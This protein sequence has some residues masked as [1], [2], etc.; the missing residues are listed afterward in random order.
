MAE[1]KKDSFTFSDKIKN[2]KPAVNPFAKKGA[3][4]IGNNGKPKQ[5]LFERSRRDA[6]F[7][8]AAAAALLM[9]PFL[10]KYSGNVND[11]VIVPPGSEDSIFDPERFGFSP[12]NEDPTGQIAQLAGRDPLSLIKGWGNPEEEQEAAEPEYESRDAFDRDYTPAPRPDTPNYRQTAPVATRAAFQRTP[13]KIKD[14]S[15]A[16]LNL[17]GGGGVGS[18]FGGAQLKA[19]ARQSSASAPRRGAQARSL[20]PLRSAA[21]PSR[22]YFGQGG[23][24]QARASRDALSKANAA[25]ALRDAMF[26][27]VK[28]ERVGGLADGFFASGGG[29]GKIDRNMNFKG[30]EPWWWD[31]MKQQEM[32]RW[33]WNYFLWRKGLVEPLIAALAQVLAK[34][35][36]NLTCCIVMGNSDCDADTF[37]GSNGTGSKAP[38]C[39][40]VN[41]ERFRAQFPAISALYPDDFKAACDAARKGDKGKQDCPSGWKAGHNYGTK[42]NGFQTR[43]K[44]L[45]GV[46][47]G[48]GATELRDRYNCEA[49]NTTQNFELQATGQ[50]AKWKNHYHVV[51]VDNYVPFP[52]GD[53]KSHYLCTSM[54][55]PGANSQ[56]RIALQNV[57]G[58]SED[59]N[60]GRHTSSGQKYTYKDKDG[61]TVDAHTTDIVR[62][63]INDGCVIYVAKGDNFRWPTFKSET[64]GLLNE[65]IPED[66]GISGEEAFAQLRLRFIE[67]YAM[68][69]TLARKWE[70]A[71]GKR[72][73]SKSGGTHRTNVYKKVSD[74]MI[75]QSI[76]PVSYADFESFYVLHRSSAKPSESQAPYS[77]QKKRKFAD[78]YQGVDN[79]TRTSLADDGKA[80]AIRSEQ[81]EF[82]SFR[83]TAREIEYVEKEGTGESQLSIAANL[84]FDPL[85]YPKREDLVVT[86]TIKGADGKTVI[87]NHTLTDA[88]KLTWQDG[89]SF[90]KL[91]NEKPVRDYFKNIP[92]GEKRSIT[93]Y[94]TATDPKTKKESKDQTSYGSEKP[95]IPIKT[96]SPCEEGQTL[97]EGEVDKDGCPLYKKCVDNKWSTEKAKDP[98]CPNNIKKCTPGDT[99]TIP[100]AVEGCDATITCDEHGEWGGSVTVD[101]ECLSN[102]IKNKIKGGAKQSCTEDVTVTSGECV[103]VIPC[104]NGQYNPEAANLTNP[105]CLN[106]FSSDIG[107]YS[108]AGHI[109]EVPT[110]LENH[111]KSA[112][113]GFTF[114]PAQGPMYYTQQPKHDQDATALSG[115]AVDN[116]SSDSAREFVNEVLSEVNDRLK[117]Q[118]AGYA[119]V[120]LKAGEAPRIPQFVD[121]MLLA[122]NTL[123][124]TSVPKAAVCTMARGVGLSSYD[125]VK[126]KQDLSNE[127]GSFAI[128]TGLS[129]AYVPRQDVE[130]IV[131]GVKQTRTNQRFDTAPYQAN[132]YMKRG[133]QGITKSGV[134]SPVPDDKGIEGAMVNGRFPLAALLEDVQFSNDLKNP[135]KG[136]WWDDMSKPEVSQKVYDEYDNKIG[137]ILFHDTGRCNL[138]GSQ[139][140]SI[141]DALNYIGKVLELGLDYKPLSK[142]DSKPGKT[143][144]HSTTGHGGKN[145]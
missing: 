45:G 95:M 100:S 64:I 138:Y 51:V 17:R 66:A 116:R 107:L 141:Q 19:A 9:L 128:Y 143:K 70:K 96:K 76:L 35:G 97:W 42:M 118:K 109:M 46:V 113:A 129:S 108:L 91:E 53:D 72:V 58:H 99:K 41:E 77:D 4:K 111:A 3:S 93:A 34:I 24:A 16:S 15:G 90:I 14:L 120:T 125:P 89:N 103:Y 114:A 5:T 74:G 23:A 28:N 26:A 31:M 134:Q 71:K 60:A 69:Q 1:N 27:P 105:E 81:C 115:R 62:D 33:K 2:S 137:S 145:G 124:R 104:E 142:K 126:V 43:W 65:M 44:C 122:K 39:C 49:I 7:M 135:L 38:E 37:V 10:Y 54:E 123:G 48:S 139:E 68:K 30:M 13:T 78:T 88:E 8:V 40:G 140:M 85:R 79:S 94:W 47:H 50:A 80:T 75:D 102:K 98:N 117:S 73:R 131:D 20:T 61:K 101:P 112:D 87:D 18:R 36:T 22:S 29:P 144:V 6:P 133:L 83:I 63:N 132:S 56:N 67:G 110:V 106:S 92:A 59:H 127:F 11:D 86:L 130:E 119:F 32:E 57:N 25:E 55:M 84:T 121:A 82:N 12:S 52:V 136:H 21:N